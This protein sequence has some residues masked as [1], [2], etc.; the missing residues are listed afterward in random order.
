MLKCMKIA[1]L[2]E[3]TIYTVIQSII[4]L[5]TTICHEVT[6][7]IE[8]W[9]SR[10]ENQCKTVSSKVCTWLP[11]PLDD[12]CDWVTETVCNL[13]EVFFKVIKTIVKTVCEVVQAIIK[14]FIL[15]PMT[16]FLTILRIVCF[17]VDTIINWVKI[18]IAVILGIPE[19][20]LCMLGIRI[21]KHLHACVTV[22]AG[23]D[24]TPV[25]SDAQVDRVLEEATRIISNRFNVQIHIHGRKMVRVSEDNLDVTACNASQ[26]F[27]S[28]AFDLTNEA[29][30]AF[31]DLF[32]CSNNPLDINLNPLA[33][34]LDIIFIRDI[35]EGD[36]VGCHI[37]GTDYV[38]V[39]QSASGLVLA[40]EIGHTGDLWHVSETKNLMN[41]SVRQDDVHNWQRCL[42][43]RSRFVQ[44]SP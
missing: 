19:F 12:F 38:I 26:L 6:T 32:G 11:W 8:E 39:D 18:I 5:A 4:T 36:D 40:H 16:I 28:E 1:E 34:V 3:T 35:R 17:I 22:L 31:G 14:I 33:D 15:V 42:F 29:N 25:V 44:Y 7:T 10:W 24:G 27:S 30:G 20:L 21:R 2:I 37:P 43:R 13:V 9:E 41:H 23:R